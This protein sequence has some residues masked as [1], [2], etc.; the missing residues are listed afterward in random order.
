MGKAGVNKID[1][2]TVSVDKT[3]TVK[4]ADLENQVESLQNQIND[5]QADLD[6]KTSLLASAREA[7]KHP[8]QERK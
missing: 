8:S 1:D 5:L 4:I 2:N 6:A 3:D 7:T